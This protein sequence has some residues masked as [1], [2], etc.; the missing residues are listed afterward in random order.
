MH[1]QVDISPRT[2]FIFAESGQFYPPSGTS[3]PYYERMFGLKDYKSQQNNDENASTITD[4][5]LEVHS[6]ESSEVEGKEA[7]VYL[8]MPRDEKWSDKAVLIQNY[9]RLMHN[10]SV[11][12][13]DELPTDGG[14][15]LSLEKE[16][17]ISAA[18]HIKN[19]DVNLEALLLDDPSIYSTMDDKSESSWRQLSDDGLCFREIPTL[20]MS[21]TDSHRLSNFLA[22]HPSFEYFMV[23]PSDEAASVGQEVVSAQDI[24][25]FSKYIGR[26]YIAQPFF[27]QHQILTIDFVAIGGD[28]K[29]YHCFYADGPI[30]NSH[31]KEGLYQQVLCNAPQ[32]IRDE[33]Q[34]IHTLAQRLSKSL[35]LNGIF[36]IEFLYDGEQAFFLELN[37]LPGL[38]GIDE[39]GLMPVLEQ[40]V[41]P[42]LMH[43]QV[44][45][46]PRTDFIF[47][48]SGQFYPPSGTSAPYYTRVFG[49]IDERSQGKGGETCAIVGKQH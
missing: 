28:V 30:Q 34:R 4:V 8:F 3:A 48:E 5:E 29:G 16:H 7:H 20:N 43:F 32:E 39:Q 33:F 12:I 24:L 26:P 46:S 36:E 41:V 1:F 23:K 40:V 13:V 6:D 35:C 38:Y 25:G 37:L 45:I 44:D 22:A 15:L 21:T 18:K 27:K 10:V 49:H 47:A 14:I 42:Y 17:L 11:L 31:W 2:D 19:G 9:F